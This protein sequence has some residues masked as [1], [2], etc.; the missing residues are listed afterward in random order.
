M[1]KLWITLALCLALC[2]SF[3]VAAC[4]EEAAQTGTVYV[5]DEAGLLTAAELETLNATAES[6]SEQYSFGVYI[7]VVD[8]YRDYYSGQLSQF[9]QH[10]FRS[11]DLGYGE[12]KDGLI[13]VL[14]M[15]DRDYDLWGHGPEAIYAFTEYGLNSLEAKFLPYFR[16]NN[17]Y[18][19]FSAYLRGAEEL[20]IAAANGTPVSY[21]MPLLY[22]VLLSVAPASLIGF[23]VCGTFKGQMKTAK[24]KE[25]AEDYLVNGSVHLRVK[26][27]QFL[28][29]TRTVRVIESSSGGHGGGSGGGTSHHSGKF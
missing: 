19:G 18:G 24:E 13:L 1:K 5:M 29:T 16:E 27:D 15:S 17:W 7:V 22:K 9:T 3:S 12:K 21:E 6:I 26:E 2:L 10:I 25:T 11:N 4:A 8:N 20:L 14:S 28:H 23:I